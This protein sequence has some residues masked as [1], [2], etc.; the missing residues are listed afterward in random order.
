[1]R[2]RF[3]ENKPA[4]LEIWTRAAGTALALSAVFALAGA[5]NALPGASGAVRQ[6]EKAPLNREGSRAE[7]AAPAVT[8][9]EDG[10]EALF[11][12]KSLAG[13]ERHDGFSIARRETPGGK[14]WVE[15]G[16]LVGAPDAAGRGGF[17]WLNRSFSDFVLKTQVKLDYP[18]DSG[19]FVRCGPTGRSHQVMLDYLPNAYIGAIFIPFQRCV[20][21]CPDGIKSLRG[22]DWN[23]LEIRMEGEPARIQVW[24][25]GGRITDFQHTTETTREVPTAGGIALQVHPYAGSEPLKTEGNT[26]RFR[27]FRIKPLNRPRSP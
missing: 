19:I 15:N 13:W 21:R 23:D 4:T 11:D 6:T 10:F 25:N 1:M 9:N 5:E 20:D 7:P 2:P 27:N 3:S 14:W 18:I 22:D 24:L 12:G 16:S 17:L 26:V 8:E